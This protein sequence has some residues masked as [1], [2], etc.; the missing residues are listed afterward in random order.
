MSIAST[1]I[2]ISRAKLKSNKYCPDQVNTSEI[3]KSGDYT[4]L[5]QPA[6]ELLVKCFDLGKNS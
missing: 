4:E 2:K 1:Q 6:G 5:W 3:N